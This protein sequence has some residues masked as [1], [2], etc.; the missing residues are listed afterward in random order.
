MFL[1][2]AALFPPSPVTD[3][4]AHML[5]DG[6]FDLDLRTTLHATHDR[7]ASQAG[8]ER[9]YLDVYYVTLDAARGTEPPRTEG[10]PHIHDDL[11]A[12]HRAHVHAGRYVHVF[13][14]D[15]RDLVQAPTW[16]EI[17]EALQAE[18]ASI[19]ESI[20]GGR[21]YPYN[22]L[23]LCRLLYSYENRDP[24]TSKYHAGVWSMAFLPP[25]RHE[26]VR[27]AMRTYAKIATTDDEAT[28]KEAPRFYEDMT[29]RIASA[30][31]KHC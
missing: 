24:V 13:G 6:P 20:A 30:R 9:E 29:A 23:N 2:G 14:P 19:T 27:A 26:I 12:L 11:W 15:A 21:N 18:L 8:H 22:T 4:D 5:V 28:L 7:V 31:E 16:P 3:F 1:Y 17:D 10:N 25:E